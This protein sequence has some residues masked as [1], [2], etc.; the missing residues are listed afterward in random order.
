M[1]I[2]D[3]E[4]MNEEGERRGK[5]A[6]GGT[7]IK[8]KERKKTNVDWDVRHATKEMMGVVVLPAIRTEHLA[9]TT[10]ISS[11]ISTAAT[12]KVVP[13]LPSL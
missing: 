12:A 7:T 4:E 13:K 3:Q 6:A 2:I 10:T 1:H 11:T 9:A 5:W 8:K